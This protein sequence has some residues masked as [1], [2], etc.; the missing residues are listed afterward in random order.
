MGRAR[1]QRLGDHG[2]VLIIIISSLAPSLHSQYLPAFLLSES[3]CLDTFL[4]EPL[5]GF[6]N[7]RV[8]GNC[9]NALICSL[10]K[11]LHDMKKMVKTKTV[12]GLS[13]LNAKFQMLG[14]MEKKL[15][16]RY[17]PGTLPITPADGTDS[18]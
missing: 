7:W 1:S 2:R 5:V 10:K 18:F 17:P 3:V 13:S 14:I 4:T 15:Q 9:L 16:G 11:Y 8:S 6:L 12:S